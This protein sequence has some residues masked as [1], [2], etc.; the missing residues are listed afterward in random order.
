[1][2]SL[3]MA[4]EWIRAKFPIYFFLA[5]A[6]LLVAC[7]GQY[8]YGES[9]PAKVRTF[10]LEQNILK[11]TD[12]ETI[13][14]LIDW[15]RR[16]IVHASASTGETEK[17]TILG[18]VEKGEKNGFISIE[19]CWGTADFFQKTLGAAGIS[20][21]Y[22]TVSIYNEIHAS[23][24]FPSIGKTAF[25]GDDLHSWKTSSR[26]SEVPPDEILAQFTHT[27]FS[28]SVNSAIEQHRNS[29]V[30]R[31]LPDVI[32]SFRVQT[33]GK[34]Y[35]Q[36][37]IEGNQSGKNRITDVST[38]TKTLHML[39]EEIDRLGGPKAAGEIFMSLVD[40]PEHHRKLVP[41][42][43]GKSYRPSR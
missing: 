29:I 2:Y 18:L 31:F 41:N 7:E 14:A 24:D 19:G 38:D 43:P 11:D 22:D 25:H 9:D 8:P 21:I 17:L 28:E 4:W 42:P 16:N 39:D 12:E 3:S 34:Y 23:M 35:S 30:Q 5:G 26:G 37:E 10:L 40:F 33:Y 6:P 36:E 32:T 13:Y 15:S 1:M 27:H 20:V